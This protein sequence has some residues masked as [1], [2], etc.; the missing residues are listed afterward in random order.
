MLLLLLACAHRPPDPYSGTPAPLPEWVGQGPRVV[1][2]YMGLPMACNLGSCAPDAAVVVVGTA[3]PATG[4]V[5]IPIAPGQV[6]AGDPAEGPPCYGEPRVRIEAGEDWLVGRA[7]ISL[8]PKKSPITIADA[9]GRPRPPDLLWRVDLDY[10]GLPEEILEAYGDEALADGGHARWSLVGVRRLQPDGKRVI[11]PLVQ[12]TVRWAAEDQRADAL[13]AFT[14][15][16]FAGLTD[17]NLDGLLEVV[18][19]LGYQQGGGMAVFDAWGRKLGETG[20]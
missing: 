5:S 6:L 12:S 18:V 4:P 14:L 9:S 11:V 16:R 20:C 19:D 8:D 2:G 3:L 1:A 7:I 17:S 15:A 10:D 13:S